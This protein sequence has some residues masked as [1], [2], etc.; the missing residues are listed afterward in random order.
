MG[1][2]ALY[3]HFAAYLS[4]YTM[5][6]TLSVIAACVPERYIARIETQKELFWGLVKMMVGCGHGGKTWVRPKMTTLIGKISN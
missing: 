5:V 2:S 4:P 6:N 1:L 3:H